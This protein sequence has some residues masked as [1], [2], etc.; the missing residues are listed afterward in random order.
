MDG[1]GCARSTATRQQVNVKL[2]VSSHSQLAV[3]RST[4]IAMQLSYGTI[5]CKPTV[6]PVTKPA[7]LVLYSPVYRQACGSAFEFLKF[8]K[9]FRK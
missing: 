3:Y 8:R 4:A 1:D 2:Y 7:G 5:V 6:I 9:E